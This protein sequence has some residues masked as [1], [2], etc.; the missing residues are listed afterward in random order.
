MV[1]AFRGQEAEGLV[2]NPSRSAS[3]NVNTAGRSP[4]IVPS[5]APTAVHPPLCTKISFPS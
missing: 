3:G 1:Q 2:W 5:S 4:Q